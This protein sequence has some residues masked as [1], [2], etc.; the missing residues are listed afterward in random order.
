MRNIW[1]NQN[2][3]WEKFTGSYKPP[4]K[5]TTPSIKKKEKQ[6]AVSIMSV[7]TKNSKLS[8]S[9][10]TIT[11]AKNSRESSITLKTRKLKK[12]ETQKIG[13]K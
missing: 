6:D 13:L 2:K 7:S 10:I 8:N 3:I 4:V 9:K 11:R 12:M 1:R 5:I